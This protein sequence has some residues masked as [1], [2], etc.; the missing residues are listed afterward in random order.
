MPLF[1]FSEYQWTDELEPVYV[2][3]FEQPTGVAVPIPNTVREVFELIFDRTLVQH[4]V[5]ETNR[6]A[7]SVMGDEKYDK[8]KKLGVNDIYAY[9][10]VMIM[11]GLV[12]LPSIHDYWSRDSLFNCPAIAERMTRDRFLEIHRYLHNDRVSKPNTLGYDCFCKV[13]IV[14]EKKFQS[15]YNCHRECAIDEAMVPYK[16]RSSL[17]QYMPNKAVR[18][19]LKVWMRAD[20]I[21]GYIAQFQVYVGRETCAERGLGAR[22]VKDLTKNLED[23]NYHIS[24]IIYSQVSHSFM[25][26]TKRVCMQQ[27]RYVQTGVGLQ[28]T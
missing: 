7:R 2:Q 17:K 4:L 5:T 25:N 18:R 20:S 9:F 1:T 10:W 22:V 28:V 24:V 13:R 11:M 16:G 12:D 26:Y 8:W 19:G 14:L 3:D 23:K 15:L 27:E 21:T 6:Y